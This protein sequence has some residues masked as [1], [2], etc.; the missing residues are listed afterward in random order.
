MRNR[1]FTIKATLAAMACTACL[2]LSAQQKEYPQPEKMT[3]GM[4]EYWTPQPKIVTREISKQ[5]PPRRM[6]SSCLTAKTSP[7]G[8]APTANR[9]N[10]PFTTAY[11]LS[12]KRPV[13][14]RPNRSSTTTSYIS[15][16]VF[17]KTSPEPARDAATAASS[18]KGC[19]KF[20]YSTATT[21]KHT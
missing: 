20:R 6:P 8:K 13:I 9:P 5:I 10:G 11:S 12:I 14:S 3:P 18:C 17:L 21:T 2:N 1:N 19:T 15:N 4:S 16:G 7:P